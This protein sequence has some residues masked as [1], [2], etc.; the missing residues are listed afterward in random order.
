M[1]SSPCLSLKDIFFSWERIVSGHGGGVI[2]G[3]LRRRREEEGGQ[4]AGHPKIERDTRL[5]LARSYV[6]LLTTGLHPARYR[7]S[8]MLQIHIKPSSRHIFSPFAI[9]LVVAIVVLRCQ[10]PCLPC[11]G[12]PEA[13]NP[14]SPSPLLNLDFV[15]GTRLQESSLLP[16]VLV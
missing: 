3:K 15:S 10:S 7:S 5:G 9:P 16:S 11:F 13:P 2:Y 8:V 12:R 6:L 4:R 1:E 14:N